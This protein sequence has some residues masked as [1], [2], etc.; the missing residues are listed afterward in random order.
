VEE[1]TN[2]IA[3][4]HSPKS[5][6]EYY[7]PCD[8]AGIA[9]GDDGAYVVDRLI[10]E[11][12]VICAFGLPKSGKSFLMLK[13]GL[14]VVNGL[15]FFDLPTKRGVVLYIDAE[16]K[17]AAWRRRVGKIVRGAGDLPTTGLKYMRVE[18][19]AFGNEAKV[20]K[21]LAV[22]RSMEPRP[23]L[24]IID[25]F[26]FATGVNLLI[27]E[28]VMR[29]YGYLADFGTVLMIDHERAA[30]LGY[31]KLAAKAF[32]SIYKVAAVDAHF[33][34]IGEAS[35][36]SEKRVTIEMVRT[37]DDSPLPPFGAVASFAVD[38][39]SVTFARCDPDQP[40]NGNHPSGRPATRTAAQVFVRA[41]RLRRHLQPRGNRRNWQ[42]R[43]K[44]F[45]AAQGAGGFV[46]GRRRIARLV[47]NQRPG[48][49]VEKTKTERG[50]IANEKDSFTFTDTRGERES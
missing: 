17:P 44:R 6:C 29:V 5:E 24:T 16:T 33:H 49:R 15:P 38:K 47:R 28:D 50:E 7:Q 10:A 34:V 40:A 35:G 32:G 42:G 22:I 46:Q 2:G 12:E 9:E 21:I 41:Q 36:E 8:A 11:N 48:W 18:K 14:D 26:Q 23:V 30:R 1:T 43:S 3:H 39:R 20:A 45:H 19:G 37:R 25:S 13:L 31:D 27:A 4:S